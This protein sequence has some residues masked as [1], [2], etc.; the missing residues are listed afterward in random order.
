MAMWLR[1]YA[2][3]PDRKR[4][5]KM[6]AKFVKFCDAFEDPVLTL[7]NLTGFKAD[8]HSERCI[9]NAAAELTYAFA[10]LLL[11]R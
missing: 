5:K 9:A 10:T 4:A 3:D 8:L 11:P 1:K 6:A 7:T 2:D